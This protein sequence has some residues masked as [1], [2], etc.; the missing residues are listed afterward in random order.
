MTVAEF[1]NQSA[2]R[3]WF[4]ALALAGRVYDATR[5]FPREEILALELRHTAL[6]LLSTLRDE[7]LCEETRTDAVRTASRLGG[8]IRAARALGFLRADETQQLLSE[9][10]CL[11]AFLV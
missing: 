2:S 5:F 11:G 7:S 10:A 6:H 8:Q 9:T 3:A 1:H 4:G